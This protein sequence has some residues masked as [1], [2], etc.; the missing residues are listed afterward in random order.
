MKRRYSLIRV[1]PPGPRARDVIE[2][3]KDLLMQSY[4]RWLPVVIERGEGFIVED[5]D[6]NRYIDFNAGIA[7]LNTGHRDPDVIAA[8]KSQLEKFIHYSLT[9]FYYELAVKYSEKL[10]DAMGY[11]GKIF[12]TNSGTE[13]IEA[14]IKVAKGYF[15][16]RRHYFLAFIGGFHGRTLGSLSLT[17]SKPI[18][19]RFFFP[20]VP[21]AV[22]VPYPYCYRCPFK[23]EYPSCGI[24]CLDYIKEWVFEKYLPG[25]ELAAAVI[26]P[27]AGEGGYIPAPKEFMVGL[28]RLVEEYGGLLMVDEVQS[29]FGRTGKLFAYMHM[30]I[31]PDLIAT[32]KAIAS[33]LPLG[34]LIGRKDVMI[35]PGGTH[36]NTFGGNP[37]SLAAAE[38]TLDKL[39]NGLIDNASRV[40]E[41]LLKRLR[42]LQE[43]YEVIGDVR[44][45]GLMIGMELVKDRESKQPHKKLLEKVIMSSFKKGLIIIGSGVSTVR[46][47]PPLNITEDVVD[48]AIDIFEE[49]LKESI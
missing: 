33:G 20:M 41:Y 16:G 2:R 47:S 12:F 46:F 1:E 14:G 39:L 35:L 22:H 44:G 31:E 34:A 30:D 4:V 7:V 37:V 27:V 43:K 25:E 40:G 17:A 26:E 6:G 28:K 15:E 32:A 18:Q 45:L 3:D 49:A 8:I 10:L 38:A 42:E 24:A 29:G 13:S 48:E 36:A 11:D 9:D 5:V 21:G 23:M 19:R